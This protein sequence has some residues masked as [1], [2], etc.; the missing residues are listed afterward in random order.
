ME[1]VTGNKLIKNRKIHFTRSA[2]TKS[3]NRNHSI[4]NK[5]NRISR[6][7]SLRSSFKHNNKN[8]G[9]KN[10]EEINNYINNNSRRDG[11]N[12]EDQEVCFGEFTSIID[13]K[14]NL[15]LGEQFTKRES[16]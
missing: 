16:L 9:T 3:L 12:R 2:K 13:L 6:S 10:I 11:Q 1:V 4:N 5:N 15:N 8:N 7:N 14:P